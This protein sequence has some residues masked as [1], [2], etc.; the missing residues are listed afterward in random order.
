MLLIPIDH[1]GK[2]QENGWRDV[3]EF[4]ELVK[5]YGD[6]GMKCVVLMCDTFSPYRRMREDQREERVSKTYFN[7][8]WSSFLKSQLFLDAKYLYK[9]LDYDEL[10]S[11]N[12]V[13]V[14]KLREINS[15]LDG[16]V[17]NAENATKIKTYTSLQSDVMKTM[18][19]IEERIKNRG[20]ENKDFGSKIASG[21][22][23]F[24]ERAR[25]MQTES[26]LFRNKRPKPARVKK[27]TEESKDMEF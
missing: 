12:E 25:K 23:K 27:S 6:G 4:K 26:S 10:Y 14:N 19:G 11:S 21:I 3:P 24:Y 22:E 16:L 2:L 20:I 1:E 15:V 9:S 13:Y 7:K 5:K 8:E 17:F 18:Q